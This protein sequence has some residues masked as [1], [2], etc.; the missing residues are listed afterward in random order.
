MQ[1]ASTP[2]QHELT[3]INQQIEQIEQEPTLKT[4]GRAD[5]ELSPL[6]RGPQRTCLIKEECLEQV[7]HF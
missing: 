1:L 6:G 7:H 2:T 4:L 5:G 3:S